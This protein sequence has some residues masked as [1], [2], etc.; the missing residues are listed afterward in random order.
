M[1]TPLYDVNARRKTVSITLNADLAAR[2]SALGINISRTAE[3]AV[4]QAF[5][6][7][8]KAKI[9]EEIRE[10][11]RITDDLV[12]RHGIPFPTSACS[13]P[14]KRTMQHDLFVNPSRERRAMYP[15]A[16]VVLQA[17][18]V[19]A[20]RRLSHPATTTRHR[21]RTR[22]ARASSGLPRWPRLRR[23]DAPSGPIYR[24]P[25]RPPGRLDCPVSRRSD[26]RTGLAVLRDLTPWKPPDGSIAAM[27]W[28]WP[29]RARTATAPS[30]GV[31]ARLPQRHDRRQGDRARGVLRRPRSGDAAVRL[32]RPRRERRPVRGRH[33]RPLDR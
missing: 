22:H 6:A 27:A 15:A 2:A 11:A 30:R 20:R 5:E 3:A 25:A 18:V 23:D 32:F 21:V 8:E 26:P 1:R 10:A 13:T 4:I 17:D 19:V 14:M 12:A 16:V 29:G 9:L 7:A 33:D 31:P 28:N 24:A